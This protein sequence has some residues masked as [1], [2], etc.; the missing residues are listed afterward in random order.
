MKLVWEVI[1]RMNTRSCQY[2]KKDIRR[3]LEK[4][5]CTVTQIH[6]K[7]FLVERPLTPDEDPPTIRYDVNNAIRAVHARVPRKFLGLKD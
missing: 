4:A 2:N 6:G 3:V 5:G 7:V 1:T